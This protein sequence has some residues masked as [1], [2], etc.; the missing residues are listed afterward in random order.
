MRC[1]V[2]D[3][4]GVLRNPKFKKQV[5]IYNI[6][7]AKSEMDVRGTLRNLKFKRQ[8]KIYNSTL[9]LKRVVRWQLYIEASGH[10]RHLKRH[11]SYESCDIQVFGSLEQCSICKKQHTQIFVQS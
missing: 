7:K 9:P 1:F 3:V 4:P 2:A 8:A 5:K 6:L 10:T 11:S